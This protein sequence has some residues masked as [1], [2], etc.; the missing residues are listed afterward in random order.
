M[1]SLLIEE[2]DK[3]IEDWIQKFLEKI[4]P[5]IY[6]IINSFLNIMYTTI[7]RN[8]EIFLEQLSLMRRKG[9]NEKLY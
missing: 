6:G 4:W 1:K 7:R 5:S 8:L 2:K 3:T 9:G